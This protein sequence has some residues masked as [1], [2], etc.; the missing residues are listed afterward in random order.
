MTVIS[1]IE[2]ALDEIA[3]GRM[4][5]LVDDE[6]RE[7]EG[8][9][10][11]AA[12]RVTAEH[13]NFMMTQGRGLICVPLTAER[14]DELALGP[15]AADNTAPFGTAF[16]KSVDLRCGG[17]VGATGRAATIRALVDPA[18]RRQDFVVPGSVFPLRSR[19]GGVLV[20][21][22][23]TE[24]SVDLARLAGLTPAGVICEVMNDD[25]TMARLP[26]LGEIAEQHG[27]PVITVA[28]LIRFRLRNEPLV[29]RVSETRLP[30]EYGDFTLRCWEN[31]VSG[32]VHLTLTVGEPFGD[33]PTL[34]RVHRA[35]TVADVFGLEFIPSRSRL[36]WSLRHMAAAGSGVL[37]YLRP[38]G[39]DEPLDD[40]VKIYGALA[41]GEHPPR[42]RPEPMGFHDFGIGAQILHAL[43]LQ[44]IR[45]ITTNPRV[46][47]GLSGYE[48]EIVDWVEMEGEPGS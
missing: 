28:D 9:L 45:V 17:G 5:I 33:T 21:S 10:V 2:A 6:D 48:L 29:R 35:D 37:L 24:G 18:T 44:R 47:K 19:S 36:A 42:A 8:D 14:A 23:Q 32:Q 4:V 38:E 40:R 22:G 31:T 11:V 43:G 3:A 12:D 30:T 41:R 34:V 25:G 13:V 15:M 39:T 46:F 20:R 27:L 16:T 1:S 26:R 7:N